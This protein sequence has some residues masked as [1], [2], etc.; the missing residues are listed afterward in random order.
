MTDF[1]KAVEA[2]YTRQLRRG[3]TCIDVGAHSGRHTVPMAQ[4]VG[5][6]GR[7]IAFE[8]IPALSRQLKRRLADLG[9]AQVEVL[10]YALGT[11]SGDAEFVV[12]VDTPECSGLQERVYDTPTRLE[13]IHVQVRRLDEIVPLDLPVAFIKIDTEGG[14]WGVI[15][16][17][18]ALIDRWKPWIAFEFGANSYQ[19]YGVD[20][21]EVHAFLTQ[22]GYVVQDILGTPLDAGQFKDS[23]QRQQVWDY[24]A[25]PAPVNGKPGP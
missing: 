7:I 13:R 24:V 9:L 5:S 8:P 15:S 21:D 20:P 11:K 6:S 10:P 22:R 18:A 4:R 25:I 3:D 19:G 23:S 1:E 2:V 12:A 14:E 17:A 16:G